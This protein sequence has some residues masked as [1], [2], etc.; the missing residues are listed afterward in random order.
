MSTT[1]RAAVGNLPLELTSFV[2]R[3]REV[4][5]VRR[6]LGE[7]RLVT[8]TGVGGTGKT[9]LALRVAAELRRAF[10]DGVWFVDLTQLHD[11]GPYTQDVQDPDVLAFRVTATLGLREQGGRP[12][13]QVLAEQLADRQLLLVLDNCEHLLPACAVL[14]DTLL[15]SSTR[16][17]ILIT[18]REPLTIAGEVVFPVPP[19]AAPD[20]GRRLSLA[21]L[22]GCESVALFVD[23]ARATA[24]DF[25]LTEDNRVAVAELCHRL[26]GLPLAIELAA[27]R[28][29]LLAPK[30]ILS[31]LTDR[32]ALLSRGSRA[33]PQ[34]Q[35]TLRACMDW[36]FDLCP[37]PE[38]ALWARLSVFAGEFELDAVEGI[39]ADGE[40][41]EADLLDLVA[42]LVDKSILVRGDLRDGPAEA[43][44]YRMLETIRDFGQDELRKAGDDAVVRRRH[45][46]WY[47]RLV[48]RASMEWVSHRQAYWLAR[49][50]G[51]HL[52]LRAA[53]E[54]C[55]AEPGEAEAALR[56]TVG[57]P[58]Q[59]WWSRGLF[60]EGR[61]W[62][63]RA[64][65]QAITA[66]ALRSRALLLNSYLA[67]AQGDPAA[68]T[69]LLDEGEDLARRLDAPAELAYA[70]CLHGIGR[71]FANDLPAA[72]ET[73]GRAR[74]TLSGDPDRDLDL[75]LNVVI[76]LGTAVGLAGDHQRATA[77]Q[78]EALAIVEPRGEG[79]HRSNALWMGGLVAWFRGD[80]REAAAQQ[81][82]SLRLKQASGSG[83]RYGTTLCLEVLA[84][85]TA[86]QQRYRRAA[87]LL[88]A[89]DAVRTDIGTSITAQLAGHRRT[90]VRH[91]RDV[92]GDAAFDDAF[93]HGQAFSFED[94]LAYALDEPPQPAPAPYEGAPTPLTGREQQVAALIS[95]GLSNK[96]IAAALVISPRTA[97]S[98][99]EHILTK[100]G[101]TS[102]AQVAAWS[103]A[104]NGPSV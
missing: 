86:G 85:I 55:L 8:L 48:A 61:R 56:L 43:A 44:R 68:A 7:T 19:L 27:A 88:G 41:P 50:A 47:E 97:E 92:L 103:A 10:P 74:A 72:V 28:I 17:R 2:G 32:F 77:C 87:T 15:R 69:R 37:K 71:L 76:A 100:L 84:W 75:Y 82:E 70:D 67:F 64:L 24:A 26:D 33:A 78:Q 65:A 29:R 52:N 35:Q 3:R 102:R 46:D 12:P 9:R 6:L 60:G 73:L 14:A 38:R 51:E 40:L 45:R 53:L 90:C 36:S 34:R 83:D 96:D 20:P 99:V 21:D 4:G 16:L 66:T 18:S 13:L 1:G 42:G 101:F 57:V 62:L 11:M 49:L 30:E 104:A 22:G 80:L 95:Q 79:R 89:A 31:R 58:R 39:C 81:V 5:E 93:Q 91:T 23:R 63:D 59:Y 94:A 54:Y 25:E 98:H